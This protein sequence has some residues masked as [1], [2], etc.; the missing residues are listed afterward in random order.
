MK[1]GETGLSSCNELLLITGLSEKRM[2]E[3]RDRTRFWRRSA[4]LCHCLAPHVDD[5]RG[6][7]FWPI[8]HFAC[9]TG[10]SRQAAGITKK[11]DKKIWLCCLPHAQM[12]FE[13]IHQ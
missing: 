12:R 6:R 10:V 9:E 5:E 11:R 3:S 8:A 1:T 2:G 7:K 4:F 13:M